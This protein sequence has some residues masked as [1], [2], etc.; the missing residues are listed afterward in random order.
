M[1]DVGEIPTPGPAGHPLP[2]G[3]GFS[4]VHQFD[5][6]EFG[7]QRPQA[8]RARCTAF[9]YCPDPLGIVTAERL[10]KLEFI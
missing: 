7:G 9:R 3:E 1:T 2:Q 8:M 6:L 4:A 10:D 5:K